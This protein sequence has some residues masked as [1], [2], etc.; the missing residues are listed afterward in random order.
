MSVAPTYQRPTVTFNR[1]TSEQQGMGSLAI[2]PESWSAYT[3]RAIVI[4]IRFGS[5]FI[6]GD[7]EFSETVSYYKDKS[8]IEV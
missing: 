2:I 1:E 7:M 4:I 8:I 6:K 5:N 3:T